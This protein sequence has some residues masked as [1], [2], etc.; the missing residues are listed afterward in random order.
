MLR[1]AHAYIKLPVSDPQRAK[2]FY[3]DVLGLTPEWEHDG[4]VWFNHAD[5]SS[6]LIFPSSGKPSGDHDQC[7]WVVDDVEAEVADLQA[8]GVTFEE[9][10]GRQFVNGIAV[11]GYFRAAWFRDSEGNLLNVRSKMPTRA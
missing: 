6:L 9:F 10:P 2:R 3:V 5:G 4:H 7:G 1:N 11:D 8:K